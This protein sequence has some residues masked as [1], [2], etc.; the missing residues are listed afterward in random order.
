MVS[1]VRV[2]CEAERRVREV[3]RVGNGLEVATGGGVRF[4]AICDFGIDDVEAF[5]VQLELFCG[6]LNVTVVDDFAGE[7]FEHVEQDIVWRI[8][9]ESAVVFDFGEGAEVRAIGVFGTAVTASSGGVHGGVKKVGF[10]VIM[11]SSAWVGL[12]VDVYEGKQSY[13]H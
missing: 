1:V 5:E 10:H 7:D 2:L 4:I 9:G 6:T 8:V 3:E 12:W 11:A 13:L